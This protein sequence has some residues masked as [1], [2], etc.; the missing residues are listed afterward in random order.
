M[1]RAR[2]SAIAFAASMFATKRNTAWFYAGRSKEPGAGPDEYVAASRPQGVADF[3][4]KKGGGTTLEQLIESK[5]IGA[6]VF[7]PDDP[8]SVAW[9]DNASAEYAEN[10]SGRAHVVLGEDLRG[11]NFFDV[12][13]FGRLM[14]NPKVTS[15]ELPDLGTGQPFA[16]FGINRSVSVAD[17]TALAENELKE[18][19]VVLTAAA[20]EEEE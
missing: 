16:E 5:G 7:N 18:D 3:L 12:T 2:L 1:E 19:E 11:Q 4:A 15:I 9:W 17:A 14:N 10:A 20:L 8:A 6:P 13:E